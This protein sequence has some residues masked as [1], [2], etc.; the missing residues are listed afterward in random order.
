[1]WTDTDFPCGAPMTLLRICTDTN[2]SLETTTRHPHKLSGFVGSAIKDHRPAVY[3][4]RGLA[5]PS[6]GGASGQTSKE[7]NIRIY[8]TYVLV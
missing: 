8:L 2:T 1:M 4:I 5:E 3:S 7:A 6:S